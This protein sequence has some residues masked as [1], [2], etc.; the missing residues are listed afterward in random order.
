MH[1]STS[2]L[3]RIITDGVKPINKFQGCF[4]RSCK[5]DTVAA[6]PEICKFSKTVCH[7]TL[8]GSIRVTCS[9]FDNEDPEILSATI[10]IYSPQWLRPWICAS[11]S[12][13]THGISGVEPA[14]SYVWT[15]F[16]ISCHWKNHFITNCRKQIMKAEGM[17]F[18][19]F[20]MFL[21]VLFE[22]WIKVG[23]NFQHAEKICL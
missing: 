21:M 19:L 10:K 3:T 5:I 16:M 1:A 4:L 6:N 22:E 15:C 2:M 13:S 7:L 18:P 9:K 17:P 8:L 20:P 14:I 12:S 11:L 23:N